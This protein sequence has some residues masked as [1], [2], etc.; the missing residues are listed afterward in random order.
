MEERSDR[1]NFWDRVT[2]KLGKRV[3]TSQEELKQILQEAQEAEM[4]DEY[5]AR[6][7][8]RA[9]EF[10]SRE[11]RDVMVTYS[12]MD[13]IHVQDNLKDIIDFSFKTA[14]SRFP[15]VAGD[16]DEILGIL[17]TRDLFNYFFIPEEFNLK[18]LLREPVYVS[19]GQNLPALV[20]EFRDKR[21]HI[22]IVVDEHGGVSGLVTL[23]DV[24]E[25][26]FGDI[27]DEF[28]LID[29][30]KNIVQTG[31]DTYYVNAT[32]ELEEFNEYFSSHLAEEDADT[33]G[34]LVLGLFG[35]LPKRGEVAKSEPFVFQVAR[36]DK[37][38]IL[39]L[40]VRYTSNEDA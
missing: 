2:Q 23:E 4:I 18:S 21:T 10:S 32:T 11:A 34:G 38:R 3:P 12:Q 9:L 16:K 8:A 17:H 37:R 7:M 30:E 28:D 1:R 31:S 29:N 20:K 24:I 13:V 15:V 19:E 26:I 6:L 14:H 33:V 36:V 25:E 27:E 22:A 35:Y 5:T 39:L 40:K